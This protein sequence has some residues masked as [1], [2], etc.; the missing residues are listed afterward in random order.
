MDFLII[1][2]AIIV[3]NLTSELV[4]SH[5]LQLLAVEIIVFFFSYE[6]LINEL[7]GRFNALTASTLIALTL[8]GIRGSAGF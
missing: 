8:I 7:R 3:P 4:R 5:N 1:L 2:I 6:V